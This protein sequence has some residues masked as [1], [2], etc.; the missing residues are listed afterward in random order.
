MNRST[1]T[2]TLK[3][4]KNINWIHIEFITL[5]AYGEDETGE[6]ETGEGHRRIYYHKSHLIKRSE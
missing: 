3:E 1:K 5:V 4:Y 2:H 6:D